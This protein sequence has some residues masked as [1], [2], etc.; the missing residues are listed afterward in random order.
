MEVEDGLKAK[1]LASAMIL[2]LLMAPLQIAPFYRSMA[3]ARGEG[4]VEVGRG[5]NY[6]IYRNGS[7]GEFKQVIYPGPIHTWDGSRWV[8]W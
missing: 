3:E 6:L 4:W 8:R 7:S 1:T 5:R 2:A